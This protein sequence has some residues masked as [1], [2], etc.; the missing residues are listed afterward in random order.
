MSLKTYNE[1][2]DFKST[3][4]PAGAKVSEDEHLHFVVQKHDATRLHY[5]FRLELDGVLKSWAIPKGPSLNPKDKRLAMEVE[6]HP[7]DYASF[8]GVIPEDNYGAGNVIV[9]DEGTYHVPGSESREESEKILQQGYSKGTIQFI[10]DGRKLKGEFTLTRFKTGNKNSWLLIKKKD[11]FASSRDITEEDRSVISEKKVDEMGGK[12]KSPKKLTA[13][14]SLSDR[15]LKSDHGKIPQSTARRK[16]EEVI[17]DGKLILTNLN[18]IFWPEEGY[19]KGDLINYY[20]KIG[21]YIL[22]YLKDRPQSLLRHPNGIDGESFFQ[23]DMSDTAPGWLNTVKFQN[24]SN[25]REVNYLICT[26]RDSLLYMVN[27]GCI[28]INPWFSRVK[29]IE[30]PDY[31]VIDLDP[32][33]IPFEKVVET[34]L[35]VKEV[36]DEAKANCFCKTSGATGLHIYVPLNAK[37]DYEIA[38]EFAHLVARIVHKKLPEITSL[39]RNPEKRK[40]KVYLDYLQN[41]IGQTLAA[42]YSVRPRPGATVATPLEWDEVNKNLDPGKFTIKTIHKRLEKIG[43]IFRGVLGEEINIIKCINNIEASERLKAFL[44]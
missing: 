25:S 38:K 36:M 29:K 4:E 13:S 39:E 17:D 43:D 11:E 34:A 21:N 3:P 8:E 23:K 2:R 35:V 9:W 16:T 22:P 7:M 30:N 6:D 27:L 19:T 18:K 41:R 15:I 14:R 24:D 31:M 26:G 20:K 12:K 1:K 33:D 40:G 42:P 28:E 44:K 5:D 32:E 10:L 37:Y